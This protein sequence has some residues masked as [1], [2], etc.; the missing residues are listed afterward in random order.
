M[1]ARTEPRRYGSPFEQER[2]L[3]DNANRNLLVGIA[4]GGAVAIGAMTYFA[5]EQGSFAVAGQRVD[6]QVQATSAQARDVT[7]EVADSAGTSA[8]TTGVAVDQSLSD[9]ADQARGN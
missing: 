8:R 7:A 2:T 3:R 6:Q 9:V 5:N 1:S 4:L